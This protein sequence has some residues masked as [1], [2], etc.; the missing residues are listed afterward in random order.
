MAALQPAQ[1]PCLHLER[2]DCSRPQMELGAAKGACNL[3]LS[4]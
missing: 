4:F 2:G 1:R 3:S